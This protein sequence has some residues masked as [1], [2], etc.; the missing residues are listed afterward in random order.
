MRSSRIK[1]DFCHLHEQASA[2]FETDSTPFA[3]VSV[4][5][6]GAAADWNRIESTLEGCFRKTTDTILK[7]DDFFVVFMQNTTLEAATQASTRLADKLLVAN[8]STR[9]QAGTKADG[10]FIE[11]AGPDAEQ[12]IRLVMN[13]DADAPFGFNRA[14]DP[15][16]RQQGKGYGSDIGTAQSEGQYRRVNLII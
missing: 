14:H 8:P 6:G 15:D 9:D 10:I 7:G 5:L 12:R 13:P 4:Q 1:K 3:A 16:F 2:A 11:I